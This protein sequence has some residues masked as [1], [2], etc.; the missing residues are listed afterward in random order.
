MNSGKMKTEEKSRVFPGVHLMHCLR[1]CFNIY[2]N[3]LILDADIVI[4][5][6]LKKDKFVNIVKIILS[7]AGVEW[8]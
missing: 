6:T 8:K 4:R 5:R 2:V 7:Y 1:L 3:R